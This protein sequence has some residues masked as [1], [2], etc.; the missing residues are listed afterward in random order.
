MLRKKEFDESEINHF[1]NFWILA[2]NKNQNKSNKHPKEYF[3]DVNDSIL[4]RACINQNL[5]DYRRYRTFLRE[6]ERKILEQV[7][8][9][10]KLSD[11]DFDYYS[12]WKD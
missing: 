11:T 5:L 7:K 9:K 1:A 8:K 6:R 4:E 3:K 2:K 10:L 12:Y